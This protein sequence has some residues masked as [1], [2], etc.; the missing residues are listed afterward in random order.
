M[1]TIIVASILTISTCGQSFAQFQAD[2]SASEV[3][4]KLS[5]PII[6]DLAVG[7]V[8]IVSYPNF[9]IQDGNVY[10]AGD[11]G[12][13]PERSPYSASYIVK[14][15]PGNSVSVLIEM[16]KKS[17]KKSL[18]ETLIDFV[19]GASFKECSQYPVKK[20]ALMMLSTI[21]GYSKFS[22]ILSLK[23]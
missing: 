16:G 1:K 15:E 18:N 22:E 3:R 9:C 7:E 6:L 19:L 4:S 21:N 13:A 17:E 10:L 8:G 2:I 11:S 20:E 23:D 12:L 5:R 14:R